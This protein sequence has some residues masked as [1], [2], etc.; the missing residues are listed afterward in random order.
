MQEH[1]IRAKSA[2][3]RTIFEIGSTLVML[4]L[5]ITVVWDAH[6]KL[7]GASPSRP[8]PAAP[9]LPSA[10]LEIA[11]S[12]TIGSA[13]AHVAMIEYSDF[14]CPACG[15]FARTIEPVLKRE[16]VESGRVMFAFKNFPL[17]IHSRAPAAA[18]AA[19]CAGQQRQFWQMH[20]L[21]FAAPS[22]LKE[23]DL[24]NDGNVVGLD[25]AAYST[26]R[27]G[28]EAAQ[29]VEA[30]QTEARTLGIP[31]TPSFFFG[32][33]GTGG[34]VTVAESMTGAR[35]VADFRSILDKLLKE[36]AQ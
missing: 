22:R 25:R 2:T 17:P 10:P 26:C 30:D 11:N 29:R 28:D 1:D 15:E 14:E 12:A 18:A 35:G 3:W 16:Y 20:D 7:Y 27:T 23:T 6:A 21:L 31:A 33:V 32:R 19:W 34:V 8:G 9:A 4:G 24:Q 13:N 36:G 5:G